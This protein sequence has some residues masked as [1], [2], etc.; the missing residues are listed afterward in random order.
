MQLDAQQL[1]QF[2]QLGYLF[3]PGCLPLPACGQGSFLR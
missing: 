3:L 1:R 2:D